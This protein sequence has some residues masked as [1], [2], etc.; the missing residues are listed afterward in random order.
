MNVGFSSYPRLHPDCK[1]VPKPLSEKLSFLSC[2]GTEVFLCHDVND[3]HTHMEIYGTEG[4]T[5]NKKS[6]SKNFLRHNKSY[7][8]PVYTR[9]LVRA[10]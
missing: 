1:V 7:G 9:T 5:H 2:V 3:Y 8:A 10:I 6:P 4:A